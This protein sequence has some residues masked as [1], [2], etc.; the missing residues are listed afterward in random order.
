MK[1]EQI[2]RMLICVKQLPIEGKT[3]HF[4]G[5]IAGMVGASVTLMA[6]IAN[7]GE[8]QAA[9]GKLEQAR[10]MLAGVEVQTRV[11]KGLEVNKE[12]LAEMDTGNYDLLAMGIV[13]VSAFEA[14]LFGSATRY[15]VGRAKRPLLMVRSYRSAISRMLICTGGREIAEPVVRLSAYLAQV[16]QAR[17]TLLHVA[18]SVPS[19][20]TGLGEIEETLAELLRTDTPL[21]RHLRWCAETLA[22]RGV[23]AELELRHG[24]V[25]NEI[26]REARIGDYDLIVLGSHI[27]ATIWQSLMLD[28]VTRQVVDRAPCPVLVI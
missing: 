16:A 6:V 23:N 26:L 3:V 13:D 28:N 21:A 18:G 24:V 20:Y 7:E 4:A 9:E 25:V 5:L 27:S 14:L 17:V 10:Q 2:N 19:M 11:R 12:I 1:P 15:L 8:R 22:Q